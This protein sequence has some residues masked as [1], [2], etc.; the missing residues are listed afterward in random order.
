MSTETPKPSYSKSWH[1]DPLPQPPYVRDPG[2]KPTDIDFYAVVGG[3]ICIFT[4]GIGTY[5]FDTASRTW[6][7]AGDWALPFYGKVEYVPELDLWFGL[8]ARDHCFSA[9]DLS[10][11]MDGRRPRLR[12]VWRDHEFMTRLSG[13]HSRRPKSSAWPP[14]SGKFCIATF[15]QTMQD[16]NYK[17]H[18]VA[19][20]RFV[21]FTGVE[22]VRRAGDDDKQ[23]GNGKGRGKGKG[24]LRMINQTT[25][26]P[27]FTGWWSSIAPSRRCSE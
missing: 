26:S 24:V 12:N 20:Q 19:D 10:S 13:N 14:P 9:S 21:L 6:S 5:C 1:C 17:Y 4:E 2:Y 16:S 15:F 11:A 3:V 27:N 7:K 22:M 18:Q 25:T 23:D 8:S